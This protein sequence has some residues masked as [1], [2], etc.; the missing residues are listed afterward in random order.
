MIGI[1]D[2]NAGN[3]R[4]VEHALS[5]LGFEYVI[6][7]NPDAIDKADRIIFPGVGD[8]NYAMNQLSQTG[9]DIFLKQRA[10]EGKPILGICLGSQIIF[11]HSS[12]GDTKC[13]GLIPGNIVHLQN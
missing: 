4:S 3:I 7:N 5:S 9:F 11:D 2:Y 10:K 12:E 1:V 6:S 8:A 13:L